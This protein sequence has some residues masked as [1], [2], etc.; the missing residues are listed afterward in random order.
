MRICLKQ[1]SSVKN[2]VSTGDQGEASIVSESE[3]EQYASTSVV[4]EEE[5]E[6]NNVTRCGDADARE[7]SESRSD[8]GSVKSS[9]SFKKETDKKIQ[10]V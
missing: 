5:R 6:D 9:F 10:L 4:S 1:Q 7:G 3:T 2:D 8:D